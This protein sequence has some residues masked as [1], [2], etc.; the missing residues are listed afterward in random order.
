MTVDGNC[1]YCGV[2]SKSISHSGTGPPAIYYLVS[3]IR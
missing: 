3:D 1:Q 2:L